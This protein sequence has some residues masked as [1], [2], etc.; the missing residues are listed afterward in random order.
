MN[1]PRRPIEPTLSYTNPYFTQDGVSQGFDMITVRSDHLD[2][3]LLFVVIDRWIDPFWFPDWRKESVG[4]GLG[5]D[6][7]SIT[8]YSET[9]SYYTDYVNRYGVSISPCR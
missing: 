8:T 3:G 5:L 1:S 4:V 2:A 9:P 6:S 7:T